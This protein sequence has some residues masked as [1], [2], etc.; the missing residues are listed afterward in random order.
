M[1]LNKDPDTVSEESAK[2]T[3]VDDPQRQD[4]T[5]LPAEQTEAPGIIDTGFQWEETY[6]G[7]TQEMPAAALPRLSANRVTVVSD[8]LVIGRM[9][10]PEDTPTFLLIPA[11][12]DRIRVS[13]STIG[14]NQFPLFFIG[15]GPDL[16]PSTGW[17]IPP[18][19]AQAGVNSGY[20][21]I[22]LETRAAIYACTGSDNGTVTVQW[23]SEFVVEGSGP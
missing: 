14:D 11:H 17:A 20:G 21:F 7:D 2:P 1:L 8:N 16:Q 19:N 9:S 3:V 23:V 6:P 18:L 22:T 5:A 13:I 15:H 4:I 10:L 12:R